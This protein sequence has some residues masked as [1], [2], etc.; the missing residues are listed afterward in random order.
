M[1]HAAGTVIEPGPP[2]W[3]AKMLTT[4]LYAPLATIN[5]HASHIVSPQKIYSYAC[6]CITI[7]QYNVF[8]LNILT[9][10]KSLHRPLNNHGDL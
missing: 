2:T 6:H 9:A 10:E 8:P 5:I 7:F 3:Q 1:N 4:K